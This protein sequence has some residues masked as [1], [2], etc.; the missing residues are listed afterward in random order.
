MPRAE[1]QS[2]PA[3]LLADY[4]KTFRPTAYDETH[5]S[6]KPDAR[7]IIAA[8][9][10]F[11]RA[12]NPDPSGAQLKQRA[13]FK[14][15]T[16]A[17]AQTTEPERGGYYDLSIGSGLEYYNWFMQRNILAFMGG[18]TIAQ[19]LRPNTKRYAIATGPGHGY[20]RLQTAGTGTWYT[21]WDI[22]TDWV[23]FVAHGYPGGTTGHFIRWTSV[24]IP[25][26]NWPPAASAVWAFNTAGRS[27]WQ[28]T[29]TNWDAGNRTE[30]LTFY[31]STDTVAPAVLWRFSINNITTPTAVDNFLY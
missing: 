30:T 8:G 4:L 23:P 31:C 19:V 29:V 14:M 11:R 28:A 26:N 7:D 22:E 20:C 21:T 12:G 9:Q 15:G 27:R 3:L 6:T 13:F 16:Q 2:I 1:D 17:M 10:H 25:P 24:P 5:Y 18:A